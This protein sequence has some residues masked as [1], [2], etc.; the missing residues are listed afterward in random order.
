MQFKPLDRLAMVLTL[1]LAVDA[2]GSLLGALP[3]GT[4]DAIGNER[5]AST[6]LAQATALLSLAGM[7]AASFIATVVLFCVWINRAAKNLRAF[8]PG[9]VF[10]YTPGWAVGWFFIPFANLF[11]PFAAIKEI[12]TRSDSSE[13]YGIVP[14]L[15]SAWWAAWIISNLVDRLALRMDD[16]PGVQWLSAGLDVVAAICCIL[17]VRRVTALQNERAAVVLPERIR[18]SRSTPAA[19]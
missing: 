19:T 2:G 10:E 14:G 3:P 6:L 9:G 15:L 8:E 18:V 1:L 4:F 16:A 17:V 12:W 5:D 7:M 13:N 11:R